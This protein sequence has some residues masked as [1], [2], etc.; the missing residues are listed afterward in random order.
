MVPGGG[1]GYCVVVW[2][3][4]GI[5]DGGGMGSEERKGASLGGGC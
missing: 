3:E 2:S 4:D 5:G 1:V